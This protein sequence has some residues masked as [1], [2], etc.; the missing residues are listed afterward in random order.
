MWDRW[1]RYWL[2]PGATWSA[3]ALRISIATSLLW[4]LWRV[5]PT[6]ELTTG[7]SYYRIGI[8]QLYPGRPGAGLVAAIEVIAWIA[9][10][11][12]LIG[13]WA[14]VAHA[15]SVVSML[16]IATLAI[17]DTP[18]WSHTD[19]PPL[20]ASLAFLGAR[21]DAVLSVDAW[22]RRGRGRPVPATC[23]APVRLVQVAV[24]G[25]F[26]VAGYCKIRSGGGLGWALSDNFRNQ[27]LTRFDWIQIE[28][29]RAASWL[30][31]AP[32][33]YELCAMLNL[34]SQTSQIVAVLLTRRPRLRALIGVA[35][36]AEVIGLG[37]VMNLWNLHWL[38]L[39]TAF[40]DWDAV[41]AW[42]RARAARPRGPA[43]ASVGHGTTAVRRWRSAARGHVA[44]ATGFVV[45]FAVQA[46]WLN[47]R[48][49][50]FPSRRSRCSRRCGR[51]RRTA[52]TRRTS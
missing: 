52:A 19:V 41:V 40:V 27:L 26:F 6:A 45:F 14:R 13:A 50:A 22:R 24:A 35:F 33:R 7:A 25:V 43:H 37:V 28:R 20:L 4:V 8:W 21:G 30:L 46:F 3:A 51:S 10:A 44:F 12:M 34:I 49:R 9:T 23:H 36:C 48:L 16:A 17:S 5:S 47:Q 29:T 42:R 32:W 31:A 39:A 2:E 38:P 18:T 1:C 11:A 15:I